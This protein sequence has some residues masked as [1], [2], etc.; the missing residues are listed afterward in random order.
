MK[1][2][3][4]PSPSEFNF[5]KIRAE[6]STKGAEERFSNKP[7]LEDIPDFELENPFLF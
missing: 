7:V 1:Y 5:D 4:N 6:L 2:W 3:V